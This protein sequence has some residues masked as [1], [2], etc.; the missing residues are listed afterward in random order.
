MLGRYPVKILSSLGITHQVSPTFT[1][2]FGG[3]KALNWLAEKVEEGTAGVFHDRS[4][5]REL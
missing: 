3:K 2:F 1:L 4:P 5:L